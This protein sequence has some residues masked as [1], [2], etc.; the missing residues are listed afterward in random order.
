MAILASGR[1]SQSQ[2]AASPARWLPPDF[3]VS[4]FEFV[5]NNDAERFVARAQKYL[6]YG[7]R[8]SRRCTPFFEVLLP[9]EV[10]GDKAL[11]KR[12]R[13]NPR[14]PNRKQRVVKERQK[15]VTP[16][17]ISGRRRMKNRTR[18]ERIADLRAALA[19]EPGSGVG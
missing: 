5:D 15:P 2:I 8:L 6:V 12:R 17:T 4:D 16:G 13:K 14:W 1:G 18:E 19:K 3:E 9:L 7:D 10:G 11:A